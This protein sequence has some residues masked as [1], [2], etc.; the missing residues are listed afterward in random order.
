MYKVGKVFMEDG[1]ILINKLGD[2]IVICPICAD[3]IVLENDESV[4]DVI[5][6]ELCKTP[7]KIIK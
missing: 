1:E 6:C 3:E 7:I 5:M 2:R 4:G